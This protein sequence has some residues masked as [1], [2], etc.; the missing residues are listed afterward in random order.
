[1]GTFAGTTGG[2]SIR[3]VSRALACLDVEADD[4]T[5]L[6]QRATMFYRFDPVEHRRRQSVSAQPLTAMESLEALLELPVGLPIP[7]ESLCPDDRASVRR[8][9]STA[10]DREGGSVTRKAV[11]PLKVEL[12]LVRDTRPRQALEAA[13]KFAPFCSR[14]VLLQRPAPRMDDYLNEAS[15]YGVGVLLQTPS[16]I[17]VPLEP[18]EYRPKRHTAAAWRFVEKLYQLVR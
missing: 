12:A 18:A 6:G 7:M 9:P 4:L 5:V 11:R 15:F 10:V 3:A 2:S 8:L 17:E 13:T 16:G 1:M 14:A